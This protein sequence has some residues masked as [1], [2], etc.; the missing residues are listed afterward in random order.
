METLLQDLRYGVRT[1]FKNPGFTSV[2]ILALALGIGANTA[3]FSV[4]NAVLL[5]PL[6]FE[7]S[8]KLVMV[9]EKRLQLGR[10]RN[11][12]SPPDFSDWRAQNQVFEDM[13]AFMGQGFNL[14][15]G[16]EPER[17]QGASVSPSIFSILRARTRLGRTFEPEEDKPGSNSVAVISS[18]LWQRSFGSDP[19]ITNKTVTLNDKPYTVVGVMPGDFVFP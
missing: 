9:W 15:S 10:I 2:A 4:V 16:T 1:M 17:I 7:Q 3:I 12:V 19:D 13:A 11:P 14:G 8:D 18:G 6:P 5:R